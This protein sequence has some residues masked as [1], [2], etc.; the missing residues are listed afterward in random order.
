MK[1]KSGIVY[2]MGNP[3]IPDMVKIGKTKNLTDR[4]RSLYSTGVPLPFRCVYAKQVEDMDYVEDKLHNAF[5]SRRVNEKREFF[6]I[7]EDELIHFFYLIPGIDCTPDK[8]VFE[9]KEDEV[10]FEK[11]SKLGERFNFSLVGLPSGTIL[12]FLKNENITCKIISKTEVEFEG[13]NHSLS[14]A[15]VIA[16]QQCGYKWNKIAGPKFWKFE[17]ETMFDRRERLE[18]DS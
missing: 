18:D 2:V 16:I 1:K 13:E 10:A 8:E 7:L 12:Y 11:A 6:R 4:M 15:G 9:S 3:A 5:A 17:G 14:S